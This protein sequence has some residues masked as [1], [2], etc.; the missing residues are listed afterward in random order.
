MPDPAHSLLAKPQPTFTDIIAASRAVLTAA[1]E[2][3]AAS[4]ECISVDEAGADRASL[5]SAGTARTDAWLRHRAIVRERVMLAIR[6]YLDAVK[7]LTLESSRGSFVSETEPSAL[8]HHDAV[9]LLLRIR[10]W[11]EDVPF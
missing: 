2:L 7:A 5:C 6:S 3:G 8:E 10:D 11:D 9:V 1:L 4:R